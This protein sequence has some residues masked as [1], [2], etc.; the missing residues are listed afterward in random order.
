MSLT[1]GLRFG[2]YEVLALIGVGGMGEVYRARDTRPI[3]WSANGEILYFVSAR[4]GTRCLYA[5]RIDRATGA[6]R[7]EPR[8]AARRAAFSWRALFSRR[9]Q[10]ILDGPV[11]RRHERLHHL[12]HQRCHVEHLAHAI[13]LTSADT[14]FL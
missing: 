11:Q 9:I 7:G 2:S 4:D 3:G 1:P 8:R 5:Q 10:R 12:R 13:A 14:A 6:R